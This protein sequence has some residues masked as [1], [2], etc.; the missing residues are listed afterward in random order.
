MAAISYF[1]RWKRSSPTL[2]NILA[3][4][5]VC[6]VVNSIKSRRVIQ[7]SRAS[8]SSI[9]QPWIHNRPNIN[10]IK[11][12]FCNIIII[13]ITYYVIHEVNNCLEGTV[14]EVQTEFRSIAGWNCV[15]KIGFRSNTNF[16]PKLS[17][18]TIDGRFWRQFNHVTSPI[19][20]PR[21]FTCCDQDI[22]SC[23]QHIDLC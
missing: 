1:L 9:L 4:I 12:I 7:R 10:I 16:W 5:A 15:G 2:K 8:S 14:P 17:I 18:V 20:V 6:W 22:A 13:N 23:L 11:L 21:K 3:K 19:I